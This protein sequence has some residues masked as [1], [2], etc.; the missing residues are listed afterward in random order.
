MLFHPISRIL[1]LLGLIGCVLLTPLAVTAQTGGQPPLIAVSGSNGLIASPP[2]P[3]TLT[4]QV[5]DRSGALMSGQTVLFIAPA[6]GASGTFQNAAPDG[7]TFLR[8][9]TGD[10]G[11]ASAVLVPNSTPGVFFVEA[12]VEDTPAATSFGITTLAPFAAPSLSPDDARSAVKQQFLAG[13]IEDETVRLHGPVLLP[14][15]TVLS[16]NQPLSQPFTVASDSWFLW[17]DPF[18][19]ARFGHSSQFILLDAN[20]PPDFGVARVTN[21]TF[22]PI[23]NLPG[24]GGPAGLLPP[25]RT[26]GTL[27]AAGPSLRRLLQSLPTDAPLSA[28][29]AIVIYGG[30]ERNQKLDVQNMADFFSGTLKIPTV[31]THKDGNGNLQP[32]D[33]MS[34]QDQ[35][36]QSIKQ[37]CKKVFLYISS[38]GGVA[39]TYDVKDELGGNHLS[40]F[41]ALA[42]NDNGTLKQQDLT[43]ESLGKILKPFGAAQVEVCIILDSCFSANAIAAFQNQGFNGTIITAA[44]RSSYSNGSYFAIANG[45]HFTEGL[46]KVWTDLM[47]GPNNLVPLTTVYTTLKA[48]GDQLFVFDNPLSGNPQISTIDADGGIFPVSDFFIPAN[49]PKGTPVKLVINRPPGVTGSVVVTVMLTDTRV[50]TFDGQPQTSF[51]LKDG[52]NSVF[53]MVTPVTDGF[54]QYT[55]RTQ[56]GNNKTYTGKARIV[57]GNGY[58]LNPTA[59]TLK[60]G[61]SGT[62]TL[63]RILPELQSQANL[64]TF[65]GSPS[66]IASLGSNTAF[67]NEGDVRRSISVTGNAPG[68]VTFTG[69]DLAGDVV[70]FTVVVTGPPATCP[71]TPVSFD[72]MFAVIQDL[73]HS[74][75]FAGLTRGVI[76]ITPMGSQVKV[77]GDRDQIAPA[78]GAFDPLGCSF[79]IDGVATGTIAGFD[80]VHV[81]YK[82]FKIGGPGFN[83]LTGEYDLATKGDFFGEP[84]IIYSVTG[85]KK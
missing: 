81:T 25:S 40:G 10:N 76:T 11:L 26:N 65:S 45:G 15:G 78:T 53:V 35:V 13:L 69:K 59:L 61:E 47:P 82:N 72:S 16:T 34:L 62:T 74:A 54:T 73:G 39:E 64:F 19:L 14:A 41:I 51:A 12:G 37:G 70:S 67:F 71:T 3:V 85:T 42:S 1:Q 63:T 77:T 49:D 46:I 43:F 58:L 52:V 21:E 57:V 32:S 36:S 23:V 18:P 8:V 84:P 48:K 83:T 31:L 79:T 24:S 29:C 80:N 27:A 22:W 66:G 5:T 28:T 50:A 75:A 33:I 68:T 30:D 2:T 17:I 38:H 7:A 6:T 9:A 55:V 20:S 44:D 60:V 4:V 56:D